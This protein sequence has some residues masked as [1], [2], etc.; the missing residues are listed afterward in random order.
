[1]KQKAEKTGLIIK[2]KKTRALRV[3]T[4]KTDPFTLRVKVLKI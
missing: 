1:M 4:S 3:D 2:V